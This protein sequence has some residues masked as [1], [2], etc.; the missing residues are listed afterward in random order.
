MTQTTESEILR[1]MWYMAIP[2]QRIKRGQMLGKQ[3]LGQPLL[4]GRDANGE[5]FAMRDICPH[6]GIPLS[7]GTFD[8]QEIECC[9]HGWRFD[10]A[11]T[12][13]HIPSLLPT[14]KFDL[15]RV[16][17]NRFPCREVQ[18]NVW[19]FMPENEGSLPDP[20]P[21]RRPAWRTWMPRTIEWSRRVCFPA[22]S[23]TRW[24]D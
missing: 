4:I 11:G 18:G 24:W 9:Y 16:L 14:Q 10:C 20:L 13:T 5:V 19:V 17:V 21:E 7:Y 12:C 8:G 6:R 15:N 3:L 1:D 22:Q 23:I 2:G